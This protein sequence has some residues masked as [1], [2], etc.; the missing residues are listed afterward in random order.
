MIY[1]MIIQRE[2]TESIKKLT[3]KYPVIAL[4]GPRQSGKTTLLKQMF[5]EYE[6]LSL[7]N[8]DVREFAETDTKGFLK[9]YS[10][11]VIFD[12]AQR[13]PALF[14]YIQGIVDESGIMGQFI[15]S[16]SQNF[17]LLQNISQ[18]LAGRVALFRLFPFDFQELRSANL[19]SENYTD[20]LVKGFYPAIYDRN[21]PAK[22]FYSNY[23][24]TY[25][26]RDVSDLI[27]I[28]DLRLFQNFLALCATRAGQL[29][30][31]NA[32]ANGCGISQPTAKAWLSA[33]ENSY[34]V[35]LLYPY[36]ENFSKRIVKTPKLYFYDTGLLCHLLKIVNAEQLLSQSIKGALFENM[37]ITEYVK[38][39]Y[40]RDDIQDIWFWRDSAGHE[41]DLLIGKHLSLDLIEFKATHTIMSDL[42]KGLTFFEVASGK[43][44]LSKTLVYA[45]TESQKRST[46]DVIPWIDFGKNG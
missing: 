19:M 40:H 10:K 39:M 8:P 2:I 35:F 22:T 16:G 14:S 31:L 5:P 21:I 32:L 18:S 9:R 37:M 23:I 27:A 46:V 6:Y 29:L 17:H 33:L 13:V 1:I 42:F 11:Y 24:Q 30:N 4:T 38:R 45:G 3:T 43:N 28:K 44:N 36:H 41:V 12:E 15:L 7:E 26:Q 34:V 20:N 25:I